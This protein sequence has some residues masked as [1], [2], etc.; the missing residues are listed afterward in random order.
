MFRAAAEPNK[1]G[2]VLLPQRVISL[3]KALDRT[4]ACGLLVRMWAM[5]DEPILPVLGL[6]LSPAYWHPPH[7]VFELGAVGVQCTTS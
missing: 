7:M 4:I 2:G 6:V 5:T 3:L 1:L